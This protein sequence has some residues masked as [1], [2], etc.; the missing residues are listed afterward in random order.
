M[1]EHPRIRLSKR[2]ELERLCREL[3]ELRYKRLRE[4]A[5]AEFLKEKIKKKEIQA[6][7]LREELK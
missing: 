4:L 6:D 2:L 1:K 7:K 5:S 3:E